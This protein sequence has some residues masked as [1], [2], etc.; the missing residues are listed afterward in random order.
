MLQAL[1]LQRIKHSLLH[2]PDE[3][4]AASLCLTFPDKYQPLPFELQIG[5]SQ[6]L[7]HIPLRFSELLT[8]LQKWI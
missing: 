8:N 4:L 6:K 3:T 7:K 1:T 2:W 5:M